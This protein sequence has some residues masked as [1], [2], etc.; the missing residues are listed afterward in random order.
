[1]SLLIA[2]ACWA[3]V[4]AFAVGALALAV[5]PPMQPGYYSDWDLLDRAC[6]C[7][8]GRCVGCELDG[9]AR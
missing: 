8:D 3:V 9:G 7:E 4:A 2:L 1:M 5:T 6:E